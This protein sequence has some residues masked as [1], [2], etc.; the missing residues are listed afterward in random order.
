MHSDPYQVLAAEYYDADLHPT[1]ANLRQASHLALQAWLASHPQAGT[2]ADIGCGDSLLAQVLLELGTPPESLLLIDSSS[3]MLGHSRK[4]LDPRTRLI[5]ASASALPLASTTIDFVL[6]SLADPFNTP[7]LWSELDRVLKPSGIVFGTTP[8]LE[9]ASRYRAI[10]GSSLGEAVFVLASGRVLRTPSHVFR[11]EQ[12][13][14][15]IETAG[16]C[17]IARGV[18]RVA[19]LGPYRLSPKISVLDRPDLPVLDWFAA[20]RDA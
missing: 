19:D 10:E 5:K 7:A 12:Q 1:C 16:L 4:W 2:C 11:P 9:W 14:Q 6:A 3:A 18:I 20:I 15:L 8:S 13:T 17:E